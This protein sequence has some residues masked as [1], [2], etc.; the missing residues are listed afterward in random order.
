[1][2]LDDAIHG[3]VDAARLDQLLSELREADSQ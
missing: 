3:R 1:L 2:R